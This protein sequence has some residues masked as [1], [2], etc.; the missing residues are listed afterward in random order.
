MLV[1]EADVSVVA[2]EVA[3]VVVVADIGDEGMFMVVMLMVDDEHNDGGD[4]SDTEDD[5]VASADVDDD[6]DMPLSC[7]C[8]CCWCCKSSVSR[9]SNRFN[10]A[11]DIP[12]TPL[13]HS[14]PSALARCFAT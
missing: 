13:L 7:S 4:V 14:F 8:F 9:A 6:D 1:G 10:A 2:V 12:M 3:A 11:T 5:V